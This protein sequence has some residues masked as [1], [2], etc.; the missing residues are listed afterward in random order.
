MRFALVAIEDL[1]GR[2]PVPPLPELLGPGLRD[3]VVCVTGAGGWIGSELCRQIL[4]VAPKS[5]ILLESSEPS[6]Y[7]L[8]QEL[9]QQLPSSVKLIAGV[10]QRRR[11]CSGGTAFCRPWRADRFPCSRL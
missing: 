10:G 7:A 2:D 9:R 6:L 5:L 11:S 4:Q 8:E 1:L 3:A